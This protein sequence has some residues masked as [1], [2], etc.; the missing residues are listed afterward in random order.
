MSIVSIIV[1]FS[2]VWWIVLFVALP[3]GVKMDPNPQK[4]FATSA[5]ISA[6]IKLKMWITTFIS[7]ILTG[8]ICW[9]II[10]KAID[11]GG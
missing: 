2:C 9:A 5:P 4:G 1:V 11:F 6:R 3:I 8:L 7:I 10:T